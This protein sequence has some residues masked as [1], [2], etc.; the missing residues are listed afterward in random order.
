MWTVCESDSTWNGS[1][2]PVTKAQEGYAFDTGR[3]DAVAPVT[4]DDLDKGHPL[5]QET[6]AVGEVN[7]DT[8]D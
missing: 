3:L 2:I 1:A 4:M 7:L 8:H 5:R 6:S